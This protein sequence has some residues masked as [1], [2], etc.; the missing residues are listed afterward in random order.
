[1]HP[2]IQLVLSDGLVL[3]GLEYK[4]HPVINTKVLH[5]YKGNAVVKTAREIRALRENIESMPCLRKGA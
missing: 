4:L 5:F 3:T 2:C 1:M